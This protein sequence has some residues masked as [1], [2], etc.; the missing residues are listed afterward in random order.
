MR[1]TVDYSPYFGTWGDVAIWKQAIVK[2]GTV[3]ARVYRRVKIFLLKSEGMPVK[4]IAWK[5]DTMVPTVASLFEKTLS[6]R[7]SISS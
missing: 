5:L 2:K 4:E 1:H 3:E 6:I 7:H